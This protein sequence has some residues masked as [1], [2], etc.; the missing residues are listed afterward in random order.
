MNRIKC[1]AFLESVHTLLTELSLDEADSSQ[2]RKYLET[3]CI[4]WKISNYALGYR[5]EEEE[6]KL[7]CVCLSAGSDMSTIP[8]QAHITILALNVV[9]Q[10]IDVIVNKGHD[11]LYYAD[12]ILPVIDSIYILLLLSFSLL[13]LFALFCL[14]SLLSLLSL[15]LYL[16]TK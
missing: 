12:S 14:S 2:L 8:N 5:L 10:F 7:G 15:S 4:N 9:F 13:F 3:Y 1:V 16:S 11:A 6:E